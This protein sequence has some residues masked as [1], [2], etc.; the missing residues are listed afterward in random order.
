MLKNFRWQ[1]ITL[2]MGV[3][4]AITNPYDE[5]YISLKSFVKY[6]PHVN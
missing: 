3:Q 1:L 5:F 4:N 6:V 2:F